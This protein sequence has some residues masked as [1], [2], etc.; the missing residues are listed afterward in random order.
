MT[1]RE[2]HTSDLWAALEELPNAILEDVDLT[3]IPNADPSKS[4]MAELTDG[5]A[6]V[7]AIAVIIRQQAIR[8]IIKRNN[9]QSDA[10][11]T[12]YDG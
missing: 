9:L 7:Q 8:D 1:E 5:A 3:T 6:Q 2:Y 4:G 10:D 12:G 11:W